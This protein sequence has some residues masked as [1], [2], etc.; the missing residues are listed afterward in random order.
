MNLGR[1]ISI[2]STIMH[3]SSGDEINRIRRPETDEIFASTAPGFWH[4]DV[5]RV[6]QRFGH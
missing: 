6:V 5:G 1:S 2:V 4:V 3:A